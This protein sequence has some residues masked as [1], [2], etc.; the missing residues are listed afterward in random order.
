[1]GESPTT[2]VRLNL[3]PYD[4][5]GDLVNDSA[6]VAMAAEESKALG[7]TAEDEDADPIDIGKDMWY[8][9]FDPFKTGADEFMVSQG[10]MINQPAVCKDETE[11]F[12]TGGVGE[13]YDIQLDDR[14]YEYY[15]TEISRR[16]ALTTNSVSA[17]GQLRERPVCHADLQAGHH[18]PGRSRGHHAAPDDHPG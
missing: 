5:D 14:G 12:C 15:L 8:Y 18:Q 10:G 17:G 1:M 3:K 16:F 2:R 4:T 11:E 7:D 9:S 6:W 13:F